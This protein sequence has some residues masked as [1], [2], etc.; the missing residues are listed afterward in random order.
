MTGQKYHQKGQL[1]QNRWIIITCQ[2]KCSE[3]PQNQVVVS[4][5]S[6]QPALSPKQCTSQCLRIFLDLN[7][8]CLVLWRGHLLESNRQCSNMVVVGSSLHRGENCE[9]YTVLIVIL[10]SW[11]FFGRS[12]GVSWGTWCR[13]ASMLAPDSTPAEEDYAAARAPQAFMGGWGHNVAVFKRASALL[14]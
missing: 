8:I 1:G 12:P 11:C 13:G 9:V 5:T 14:R 6:D 4:S 7:N 3:V 2:A 10:L